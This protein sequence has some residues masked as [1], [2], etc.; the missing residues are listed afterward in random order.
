[1]AKPTYEQYVEV[2]N[3]LAKKTKPNLDFIH[4][5]IDAH[6]GDAEAAL[7]EIGQNAAKDIEAR[8]EAARQRIAS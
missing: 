1:M 5:R 8:I 6:N 3:E 4:G 2:I 7:R